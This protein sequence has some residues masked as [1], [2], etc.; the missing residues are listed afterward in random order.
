MS[1]RVLSD[2]LRMGEHLEAVLA[3]NG[4]ERDAGSLRGAHR[5]R[6]RGRDGDNDWRADCGGLLHHLDRDA[7]GEQ[8]EAG[9][10]R[11]TVA[12]ERAGELVERIVTADVLTHRN[13]TSV[14]LPERGGMHGARLAIEFLVQ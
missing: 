10:R 9:T 7:A 13:E 4:N 8:D 12:R 2:A 11:N 3:C 6:S 5:Q 14:L 1:H